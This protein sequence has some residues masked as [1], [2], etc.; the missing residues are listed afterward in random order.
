MHLYQQVT[1]T[2]YRTKKT[3]DMKHVSWKAKL[4]SLYIKV[5]KIR[6]EHMIIPVVQQ[7]KAAKC[8][9]WC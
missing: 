5:I 9:S 6:Y 7:A 4:Y 3:A 2:E 8:W 1:F